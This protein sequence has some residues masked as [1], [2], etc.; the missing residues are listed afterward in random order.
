MCYNLGM[1]GLIGS[2]RFGDALYTIDIGQNDIAH[3]FDKGLSYVQVVKKIPLVLAEIKN[4]VKV[5]SALFPLADT[6]PPKEQKYEEK[7]KKR[8]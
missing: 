3:S 1:N 7:L 8:S 2:D 4:A 6:K 5:N